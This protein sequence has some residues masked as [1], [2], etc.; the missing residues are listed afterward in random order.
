MGYFHKG[1]QI[2]DYICPHGIN[3]SK[4]G[5]CKTCALS[6]REDD[7]LRSHPEKIISRATGKDIV[8]VF[9]NNGNEETLYLP[10]GKYKVGSIVKETIEEDGYEEYPTIKVVKGTAIKVVPEMKK[11]KILPKSWKEE[12]EEL[13]IYSKD[14]IFE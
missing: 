9:Q 11:F 5:E 8:T 2:K 1:G 7:Y 3:F 12:V 10:T 14:I 6:E 13:Y 4:F